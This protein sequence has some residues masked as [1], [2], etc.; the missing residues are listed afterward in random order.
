MM[1]S[2]GNHATLGTEIV[3]WCEVF[4]EHPFFSQV[5]GFFCLAKRFSQAAGEYL[6]GVVW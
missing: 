2:L 3:H 4:E 5:R 1:V 6:E